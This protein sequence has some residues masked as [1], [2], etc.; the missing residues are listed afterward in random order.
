METTDKE[1]IAY[2]AM[3]AN[4][5]LD[6]LFPGNNGF[7]WATEKKLQKAGVDII[8]FTNY[9]EIYID[10]K[11]G[12]GPDYGMH[13]EDYR[14]KEDYKPIGYDR[15]IAIEIDQKTKFGSWFFTNT[16]SKM[17]DYMIYYIKDNYNE[18]FALI[19]YNE[20]KKVSVAHKKTYELFTDERGQEWYK[21]I[22]PGTYKVHISFNGTG[23]YIKYPLSEFNKVHYY[24]I[25]KLA[26]D[27]N[28]NN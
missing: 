16:E 8:V 26:G 12:I 21:E 20:I 10:L 7:K 13:E 24:N 1:K 18:Y 28:E 22:W 25:I 5:V 11:T 17:S 9:G 4:N 27:T 19:D 15:G 23:H 2:E 3:K 14:N 6:H